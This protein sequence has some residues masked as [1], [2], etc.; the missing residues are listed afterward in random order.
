MSVLSLD[1][2]Q[3]NKDLDLDDYND[4]KERHFDIDEREGDFDTTF[5]TPLV[6]EGVSCI[7]KV[8]NIICVE[9]HAEVLE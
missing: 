3:G 1:V 5:T 2:N 6:V 8:G 7:M 4:N 9:V